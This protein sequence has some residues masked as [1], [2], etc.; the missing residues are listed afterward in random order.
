MIQMMSDTLNF[1]IS[2]EKVPTELVDE[3]KRASRE[4]KDPDVAK[5][6][7]DK[8][9]TVL[10]YYQPDQ[11]FCVA[12]GLIIEKQRQPDGMLSFWSD[13]C[14]IFPEDVTALRMM[15]RWFRRERRTEAGIAK[16][17]SLFPECRRNLAEAE[18]AVLG[19]SE[20]RAFKEVD[21]IMDAILPAFPNARTI[22]MR[23]LKVL[24]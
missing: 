22:R 14:R 1:D 6:V 2:A 4:I 20:L 16:I 9:A 7:F 17:H 11:D 24:K 19:F 23:Y 3:A 15:M 18:F 12:C 10:G 8:L 21:H 13:L 5:A